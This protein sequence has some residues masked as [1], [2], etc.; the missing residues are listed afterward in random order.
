[1]CLRMTDDSKIVLRWEIDNA[2]A[3]FATGRVVSEVFDKGGFKWT[4][5]AVKSDRNGYTNFA[6]KCVAA[7]NGEWK[8]DTE[9]EIR[10]YGSYGIAHSVECKEQQFCFNA[11]SNIWVHE[12]NWGWSIMSHSYYLNEDKSIL[13]FHITLINS[14]SGEADPG[15]F[16]VPNRMS[17]VILKIGDEKL[18]VSK[19]LLAVQSPVFET[20]FFGEFVEKGK[21]EVEIKDVDCKEFLDLLHLIYLGTMKITDHAVIH[22][23]KLADRFQMERVLNQAKIHLTESTGFDVMAKLL[24]AD[25]YNLAVVKNTCLESFTN[26]TE[27]HKKLQASPEYDSFS[28]NMKAAICDRSVKLNLQ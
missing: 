13:E 15:M 6:L 18:H 10:H 5:V 27:L 16:A 24:I 20:L 21:A 8:C 3:R 9:L 1:I 28:E 17:N 25:Q 23:L 26:A 12:C 4:M 19:E 7:Y 2:T 11:N 14:E 22:M